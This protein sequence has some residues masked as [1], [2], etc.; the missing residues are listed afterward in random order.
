MRWGVLGAADIARKAVVPAIEASRNGQVVAI[1][2]RDPERAR[3]FGIGRVESADID[4][5]Y[6]PL[7]NSLHQEWTSKALAAGKHVLCEKPL[8]MNASEAEA[9][10]AA[11]SRHGKL[12]MEGFMYRFHPRIRQ[13]VTEAHDIREV[14]ASFGFRLRD[15]ANYRARPELG[16]GALYDVGCYVI[17]LTAWILGQPETVAA[18]GKSSEGLDTTVSIELGFA[19]GAKALEEIQELRLDGLRIDKPFTAWKDPDD[20]YRL[21]VEAFADAAFSGSGPPLSLQ[22]SIANLRVMDLV[23]RR[24]GLGDLGHRDHLPEAGQ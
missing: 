17:N 8:A 19:S 5:V 12:L 23:R 7:V 24:L 16:G 15:P 10:A 6:I 4:A 14:S 11:A 18:E 3:T 21:M 9:M 13:V 22:D 20:P 1:A 2:S